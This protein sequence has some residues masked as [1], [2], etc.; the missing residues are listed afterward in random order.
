M[1]FTSACV[2]TGWAPVTNMYETVIWVALVAAV[3]S[4]IFEMIYR[5]VFTRLAGSAVATSGH[6]HR[7]ERAAPGSEHQEPPAGLAQ[8]LLA[9]DPRR[10]PRSR[11]MPPSGWRG[12][13]AWS[14]RS[15]T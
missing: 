1:A 8:Q 11:A 14:R 7:G 5:K 2:I 4:F 6:D 12:C 3:L 9:D 10:V 15:I 13:S